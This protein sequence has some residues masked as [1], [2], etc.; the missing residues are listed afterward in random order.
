MQAAADVGPSPLSV[1]FAP[2][3]PGGA[4]H[5]APLSRRAVNA[6][7]A[8][9][10]PP[11]AGGIPG[12]TPG[13]L[14]KEAPPVPVVISRMSDIA[15]EGARSRGSKVPV[16]PPLPPFR[17]ARFEPNDAANRAWKQHANPTGARENRMVVGGVG[18]G[19]RSVGGP[20]PP[21]LAAPP[22]VAAQGLAARRGA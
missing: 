14:I 17:Y 10:A 3:G 18:A 19:H 16:A 20:A 4:A 1:G 13:M 9:E 6:K 2:D 12:P 22:V 5:I 7:A 21:F 15:S 11:D 8:A